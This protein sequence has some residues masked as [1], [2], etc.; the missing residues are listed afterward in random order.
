MKKITYLCL[1]LSALFVCFS[2]TDDSS[3]YGGRYIGDIKIS[4]IQDYYFVYSYEHSYLDIQPTIESDYNEKDLRYEWY[5]YD[6]TKENHA[7]GDQTPYEATLIGEEKNLHYEMNLE[8]SKY[9]VVL[10]VISKENEIMSMYKT[11][12][13]VAT[14]LSRGFYIL[15][16]TAEGNTEL[17]LFAP[18]IVGEEVRRENL[19]KDRF[20]ASLEGSPRCIDIC[21]EQAFRDPD[22]L[23]QGVEETVGGN[24]LFIST[25]ADKALFIRTSDFRLIYDEKTPFYGTPEVVPRPYRA[26][27]G[28]FETYYLTDNG[29]YST[30]SVGNAGNS[31]G[32]FG[33]SVN[34]GASTHVAYSNLNIWF[35]NETD[36]GL[37][38]TDFNGSALPIGQEDN[39]KNYPI[40]NTPY[41]CI[42]CGTNDLEGITYFLL[43]DKSNPAKKLIYFLTTSY[44]S[45]NLSKVVELDENS[46]M[47]RAT[48]YAT[49]ALQATIAYCAVD[50]KLY[51]YDLAGLMPER[52]LNLQGIP[53]DETITYLSNQYLNYSKDEAY[54]FDYLLVGTQK[55]DIYHLYMYKMTGGEPDGQPVYTVTGTGKIFSVQY[56]T[57]L[58]DSSGISSYSR[59]D[60]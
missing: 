13:D 43:Q 52:E 54:M 2:C 27:R 37:S 21:Y 1:L 35:W 59:V 26:L 10:K 5:I 3:D 29:V 49:N 44:Y 47:A 9:T 7:Y 14:R 36:N 34:T 4:G 51:A 39:V 11:E 57:P 17:D 32:K 56:V 20:N 50:N 45:G 31:P 53:S 24:N 42:T 8:S 15:K 16:E 28:Y 33:K 40:N 18:G 12:V 23:E 22:K 60:R 19:L 48:V 41:K 30:Y 46:C 38:G 55:G 6:P 25:E 58:M